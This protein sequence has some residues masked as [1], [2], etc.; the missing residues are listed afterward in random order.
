MIADHTKA[1]SVALSLLIAAAPD[2][3]KAL[4]RITHPSADDDDLQNALQ[5]IAQAPGK[6]TP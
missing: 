4:Q 3:L 1:E 2:L 5:V 6:A